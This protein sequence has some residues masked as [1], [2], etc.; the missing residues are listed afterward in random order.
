MGAAGHPGLSTRVFLDTGEISRTM[1]GLR[2]QA[3]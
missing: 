2:L 1:S 3:G